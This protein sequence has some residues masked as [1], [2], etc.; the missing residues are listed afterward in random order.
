MT[1]GYIVNALERDNR[2]ALAVD[3]GL[4]EPKAAEK[5]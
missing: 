4:R 3:V 5:I 2:P 1:K